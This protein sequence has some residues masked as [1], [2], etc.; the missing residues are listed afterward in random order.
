LTKGRIAAL[1]PL[2]AANAF[3]GR[4]RWAGTFA[5]GGAR[6]MHNAFMRGYVTMT[7]TCCPS[8]VPLSVRELDPI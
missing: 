5:R 3:V 2:P 1:S 7:G 8:K 6:R 4:V